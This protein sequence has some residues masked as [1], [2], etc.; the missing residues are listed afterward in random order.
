MKEYYKEYKVECLY[1]EPRMLGAVN[2]FD[3]DGRL[4]SQ[5]TVKYLDEL[6]EDHEIGE[7]STVL[8]VGSFGG[9]TTE[10]FALRCKKVY[11]VDPWSL[12]FKTGDP[13]ISHVNSPR[14]GGGGDTYHGEKILFNKMSFDENIIRA[15]EIFDRRM[16]NYSNVEKV[17][18]FSTVAASE[19]EDESIDLLYI[20]AR[21]DFVGVR[22]DILSYYPK[23]KVGGILAGH[24]YPCRGVRGCVLYISRNYFK[25]FKR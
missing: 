9:V 1:R 19:I 10:L 14:N 15:E 16:E 25:D 11:A 20:D 7:D 6:M 12:Q 13:N 2:N 17:K 24:D 22:G 21:H 23:L 18:N 3:E 4:Q 8:E 5:A